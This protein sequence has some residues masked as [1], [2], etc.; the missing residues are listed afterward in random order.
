MKHYWIV[1]CLALGLCA[2]Q[3]GE[4][5]KNNTKLFQLLSSNETGIGF[6]NELVENDSL[7][8]FT[9]PYIYMGGGVSI[10][11]INNDGLSDIYFT[12][13]MVENKL[14]LNKGE[15]KFEDITVSAG[16]SADTV[17]SSNFIS[18]LFK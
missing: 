18:P 7:N 12:G 6:N 3:P 14:Y 10:G 8:Y 4:T 9:Y 16:V 2:C 11:D 1:G 15:M 17:I 5:E 13:N